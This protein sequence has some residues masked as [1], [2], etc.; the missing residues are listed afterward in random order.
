MFIE[1]TEHIFIEEFHNL[2]PSSFS[3]E[4][5]QAL[6]EY[7]EEDELES[8]EKREFDIYEIDSEYQEYNSLKAYQDDYVDTVDKDDYENWDDVAQDRVV[9]EFGDFGA[10]IVN[11]YSS[12]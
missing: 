4:G 5:L 10:A 12:R 1:V 2:R 6:F 8:G 9:I 11:I 7:L 3:N